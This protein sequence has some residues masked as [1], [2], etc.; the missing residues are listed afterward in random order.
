MTVR[1]AVATV[2]MAALLVGIAPL[3]AL[4]GDDSAATPG[5][6]ASIEK[7]VAKNLTDNHRVAPAR[8]APRRAAAGQ[9][10]GGG[11][12]KT[13]AIVAI[14]GTVAGLATTYYVVK[15]MRKQTGQIGQ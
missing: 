15:Q 6:R 10:V 11:G 2:M 5:I 14:V 7:V 9:A 4:A 1:K 12:G 8:P 3:A 13:M